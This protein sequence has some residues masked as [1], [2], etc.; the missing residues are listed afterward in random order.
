MK[1]LLRSMFLDQGEDPQAALGNYTT[2]FQ[3]S[4]EFDIP[5]DQ[6]I[7]RFIRRFVRAHN[8]VP[9]LSTLTAHFKH[10]GEDETFDRVE[11]LTVLIPKYRGDF[12][13]YLAGKVEDRKVR[14][15][16]EILKEA[17]T[18][19]STG[20]DVPGDKKGE[21]KNIKGPSAAIQYIMNKGHDIVAPALSAKLYGEVTHDGIDFIKEYETVESDPLAG[22]G[23]WCGLAQ[24][25]AALSGAKRNELWT[26][27]AFT[28]G[29]KSTLMLNWAYTQA[30]YFLHGS[31]IFSLEMPYNQCRR[32]LYAMHSIH[33]KFKPIRLELG[34]QQYP[35]DQV[36]LP[37]QAIR[38]GR[39]NDVHPN[40]RKFLM[41]YVVPDFNGELVI[42]MGVCDPYTGQPWAHP[43]QYG[44]IHIEQANPDKSDFTVLDVK[45]KAEMIFS[46][47]RF[48]TLF[49][50][51]MGLMAPRQW[52]SSTT[53]R[54]NE[55]IRDLKRLAMSFNRG[56]GMAVVGLFQISR[57]GMKSALKVKEKT[58]MAQYNLTHLSYANEAERS[59]DVVTASWVDEDLSRQNRVQF[60]CL[61]S[62]DDKSFEPF[63]ARVEWPCRRLF[64]CRD[65]IG[66]SMGAEVRND[67]GIKELDDAMD[68]LTE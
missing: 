59:S 25:D 68:E 38:D 4:L 51:H 40:A 10:V 39:L 5:E 24:A 55:V 13:N 1:T 54:L 49:V 36:G 14:A 12:D 31:L 9:E 66:P 45:A 3:T 63:L 43:E 52:V 34:L 67:P 20:M 32:I 47:S 11:Q 58:G 42:P 53:D 29:L 41:E 15:T 30:V 35:D 21:T 22:I 17:S 60:Q 23:Q 8:H 27:A 19:L 44:K 16:T 61:K 2:F 46:S 48:R 62:R 65:V 33:D 26:H 64:T 37:Y 18:I 50:D 56:H 6:L 57:E 28:G 7:W